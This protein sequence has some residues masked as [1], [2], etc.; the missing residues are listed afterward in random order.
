MINGLKIILE[1]MLVGVSVA[2]LG[3]IVSADENKPDVEYVTASIFVVIYATAMTLHLLSM[4]HGVVTSALQFTFYLASV[5]CGGFTMRYLSIRFQFWKCKCRSKVRASN[6]RRGILYS[7]YSDGGDGDENAV[8]A[9]ILYVLQYSCI[10]ALFLLNMRADEKPK[11]VD[12]RVARQEHPSPKI[13]ASFASKLSFAWMERL[14]WK[15]Y[16][17]PLEVKDLWELSPDIS[18]DEVVPRFEHYYRWIT[19]SCV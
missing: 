9:F 13:S 1:T 16:K 10:C 15:G 19:W 17:K 3:L 5:T 14:F 18:L 6:L 11:H 12:K 2:R 7:R 8:P 4:R